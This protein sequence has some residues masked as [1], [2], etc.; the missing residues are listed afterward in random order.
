MSPGAGARQA[1]RQARGRLGV[2]LRALRDVDRPAGVPRRHALGHAS[3]AILQ[4]EPDWR[5]LPATTPA[6]IRRLL[7]RC[8]EKDPTRRLRDIGDARLDIE[9]AL[10][11]PVPSQTLQAHLVRRWPT[12]LAWALA[13]SGIAAAIGMAVP[14]FRSA[15]ARDADAVRFTLAPPPN[16]VFGKPSHSP[17]MA[18]DWRSSRCARVRRLLWVR[19]LDSL[20]AQSLPG[21]KGRRARSGHPTVG[22]WRLS[23]A[24]S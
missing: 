20:E 12:R 19:S 15:S 22:R 5:A 24:A 4:G 3:P 6:G 9:E 21:M 23:S 10:T 1:G 17:R 11:T 13:A 7:R 16:T 18:D 2:R 8:L 14:Y